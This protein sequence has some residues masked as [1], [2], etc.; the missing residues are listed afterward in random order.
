MTALS[1]VTSAPYRILMGVVGIGTI[2]FPTAAP[3]GGFVVLLYLA[4]L[5]LAHELDRE[6]AK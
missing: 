4:L 3:Y 2:A 5:W 6:A 1:D